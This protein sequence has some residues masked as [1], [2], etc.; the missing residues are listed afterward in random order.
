MNEHVSFLLVLLPAIAIGFMNDYSRCQK[1][2]Y[3]I[4][5]IPGLL[6]ARLPGVVL[7]TLVYLHFIHAFPTLLA[8]TGLAL[9]PYAV[10]LY[11]LAAFI[12]EYLG[13]RAL[14]H[15]ELRNKLP[16]SLGRAITRTKVEIA[17]RLPSIP[18]AKEI[19]IDALQ[20]S[21]EVNNSK[22]SSWIK[23][24]SNPPTREQIM[25]IINLVGL[26]HMKTVLLAHA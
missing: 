5:L 25:K 13:K 2:W 10:L 23:R 3:G 7:P 12:S 24:L 8:F 16:L 15:S 21:D 9:K 19:L 14:R 20:T 6:V 18:A 11:A 4:R 22:K 1:D 17:D 26:A